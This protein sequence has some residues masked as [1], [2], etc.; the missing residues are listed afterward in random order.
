MAEDEN[1]LR[2]RYEK[3]VLDVSKK[4]DPAIYSPKPNQS[5]GLQPKF[6][7]DINM[8]EVTAPPRARRSL[9]PT[10]KDYT[11]APVR[12]VGTSFEESK[13]RRIVKPR[14]VTDTATPTAAS[15]EQPR[16]PSFNAQ[17]TIP[18]AGAGSLGD[19][20]KKDA[21]AEGPSFP[22]TFGSMYVKDPTTGKNIPKEG[23]HNEA[24]TFIEGPRIKPHELGTIISHATANIR[25]P[26]IRKI[27][28]Q[29]IGAQGGVLDP[30]TGRIG[31]ELKR[32]G[33]QKLEGIKGRY[34]ENVAK[35]RG[36]ADV[37]STGI[38]AGADRYAADARVGEK[39]QKERD[40]SW[41]ESDMEAGKF[42]DTKSPVPPGDQMAEISPE[43]KAAI[44]K[45][46]NDPEKVKKFYLDNPALKASIRQYLSST[47]SFR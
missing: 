36:A 31:S 6:S 33:E 16:K 12:N 37:E 8:A 26:E 41:K 45:I 28:A 9:T 11:G 35:I 2:K 4:T 19:R 24:G 15:I 1:T 17:D 5:R 30:E 42:Y 23:Y 7:S 40:V 46:R 3:K 34:L 21:T 44:D 13:G 10:Q 18:K 38:M 32:T 20:L 47:D 43:A 29:S 22:D 27:I 14:V 39:T 25:D